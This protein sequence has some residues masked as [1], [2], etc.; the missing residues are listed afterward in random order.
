LAGQAFLRIAAVA[1]G[2]CTLSFAAGIA[3][4]LAQPPTSG[5]R[6]VV[7][8]PPELPADTVRAGPIARVL[9]TPVAA[10]ATPQRDPRQLQAVPE[11]AKPA[12][13]VKPASASRAC[14]EP[15]Q[16]PERA[17]KKQGS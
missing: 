8:I 3:G 17:L 6:V 5:V 12:P 7:R 14:L 9:H 10:A 11:A 16:K 4:D 13:L 1:L 15:K 2:L